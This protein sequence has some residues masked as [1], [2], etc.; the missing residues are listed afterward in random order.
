MFELREY[1]IIRQKL[2]S[3]L[4]APVDIYKIKSSPWAS[5]Y[6]VNAQKKK[7]ILKIGTEQLN[8]TGVE[9]EHRALVFLKENNISNIPEVICFEKVAD[10]GFLL[11]RFIESTEKFNPQ[12]LA[13]ILARI[14]A[15][16]S[17]DRNNSIQ[18]FLAEMIDSLRVEIL[19]LRYA[20]C[21]KGIYKELELCFRYIEEV[22]LSNPEWFKQWGECSFLNMDNNDN[23]ISS[24]NNI[25]IL[26]WHLSRFGD[27]A[28]DI[29]RFF[30]YYKFD[31]SLFLNLYQKSVK[32]DVFLIKRIN[33]Y[34][35]INKLL[36]IILYLTNSGTYRMNPLNLVIDKEKELMA[37]KQILYN[38]IKLKFKEIRDG[39]DR[40]YL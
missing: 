2:K 23:I 29:A 15:I 25:F 16:V 20:S 32:N 31:Q 1:Q 3:I 17:K 38:R 40:C 24:D 18:N 36:L 12:D 4:R 26:D 8:E 10:Y 5:I 13:R 19:Y 37:F 33:L 30:S 22:S 6:L 39:L 9:N 14:H 35:L 27:K 28:W 7:Y 21:P 34:I 11:L